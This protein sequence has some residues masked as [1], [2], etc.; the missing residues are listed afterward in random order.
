MAAFDVYTVEFEAGN[1]NIR[2]HMMLFV[3]TEPDI[4]TGLCF[5]VTG[6]DLQMEFEERFYC[7][8]TCE[9][10]KEKTYVGTLPVDNVDEL[11]DVCQKVPPPSAPASLPPNTHR[12]DCVDWVNNVI[13]FLW[14]YDLVHFE[15]DYIVPG[16]IVAMVLEDS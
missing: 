2:G 15:A 9:R 14:Q 5:H 7:P 10:F 6:N 4:S 12:P 8:T 3:E 1:S 16:D 13:Y 11:R